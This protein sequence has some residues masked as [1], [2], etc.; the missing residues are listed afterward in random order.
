MKRI[1][2]IVIAVII[3]LSIYAQTNDSKLDSLIRKNYDYYQNNDISL[4]IELGT[5]IIGSYSDR[6]DITDRCGILNTLSLCYCNKEDF[7]HAIDC[8]LQLLYLLLNSGNINKL[9]DRL[10][11]DIAARYIL[12]PHVPNLYKL[13]LAKIIYKVLAFDTIS[14]N[15]WDSFQSISD[16]AKIDNDYDMLTEFIDHSVQLILLYNRHNI[17]LSTCLSQIPLGKILNPKDMKSYVDNL[18]SVELLIF[19]STTNTSTLIRNTDIAITAAGYELHGCIEDALY[20]IDDIIY[21]NIKE[22]YDNEQYDEVI[23]YKNAII[24]HL[25]LIP[26]EKTARLWEYVITAIYRTGNLGYLDTIEQYIENN[27]LLDMMSYQQ[28]YID[29]TLTNIF[30]QINDTLRIIEIEQ[31]DWALT[32]DLDFTDVSYRDLYNNFSLLYYHLLK[33]ML[34][35]PNTTYDFNE[36]MIKLGYD[37]LTDLINEVALRSRQTFEFGYY[38]TALDMA[39]TAYNMYAREGLLCDDTIKSTYCICAM[40]YAA[41][42]LEYYGLYE[43]ATDLLNTAMTSLSLQKL[44]EITE[45]EQLLALSAFSKIVDIWLK[46]PDNDIER[47][48]GLIEIKDKFESIRSNELNNYYFYSALCRYYYASKNYSAAEYYSDL[49]YQ[50]SISINDQFQW[51][52]SACAEMISIRGLCKIHLDRYDDGVEDIK[53]GLQYP[54]SQSLRLECQK[55]LM[56]YNIQKDSEIAILDILNA[57]QNIEQYLKIVIAEREK[58]YLITSADRER[59]WN[60]KHRE[61]TDIIN[62]YLTFFDRFDY[63]SLDKWF[64]NVN[65]YVADVI[66]T[67]LLYSKGLLL[68]TDVVIDSILRNNDN[69]DVRKIYSRYKKLN[70]EILKMSPQGAGYAEKLAMLQTEEN[71]LMTAIRNHNIEIEETANKITPDDII[72]GLSDHE[73]AIEFLYMPPSDYRAD[74]C[75]YAI[76]LRN[77]NGSNDKLIKVCTDSQLKTYLQGGIV[78]SYK[79]IELSNLIW[80]NILKLACIDDKDTIYFSP[81]GFLH[82]YAIEYLPTEDGRTMF[83]KYNII[84]LTSTSEILSKKS[85]NNTPT[86]VLYGGLKYDLNNTT[87]I[88]YSNIV[89]SYRDNDL[90]YNIISENTRDSDFRADEI[91]ELPGTLDEV[92]SIAELLHDN[93]IANQSFI[94]AQGTEAS[95]KALSGHAPKWLLIATH[96]FFMSPT[97][98]EMDS[99]RSIENKTAFDDRRFDSSIDYSMSRAG[100]L[101]AGASAALH[102][103]YISEKDDDGILT[104]LEISQLNL[105]NID[106]VV[107]SACQTAMGDITNDGVAGLQRGF[108]KS[109]VQTIVMSLWKV[110]DNATAILMKRFYEN[111]TLK[112][113]ATKRDAFNDAIIYLRNY[114]DK[115]TVE[116]DDLSAEPVYDPVVKS[117][118]YPKKTVYENHKIYSDPYYWAAFIMLD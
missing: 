25:P 39:N 60:I 99:R 53:R 108:K 70:I 48:S 27:D 29:N 9:C 54:R 101:F 62:R 46:M 56:L 11:K 33:V 52:R 114:E 65:S 49:A 17:E 19:G 2:V 18:L 13:D 42:V 34:L 38:S 14:N 106:L 105:S 24:D 87:D 31:P 20:H 73:I 68:R 92:N 93:G 51:V 41:D 112:R 83:E 81:D 28:K 75:Y 15:R 77:N 50:S 118:V 61:V 23:N 3:P 21:N 90:V 78:Q 66:Y 95:F 35:F 45:D 69:D 104:A 97:R 107:L 110:S 47:L 113:F 102:G 8:D 94:G 44:N 111:M 10:L 22:L 72:S 103:E 86:S 98:A 67:W 5:K 55:V 79:S 71:N 116:Y 26:P 43:H 82:Q 58:L 4:S 1:Y 59:A 36:I 117:Y 7:D 85:D 64:Q 74:G 6:L 76:V 30:S 109:G 80:S 37:C 115:I 84:R 32:G 89:G 96:G 63:D 91:K 40:S 100:L 12:Y 57:A 16:R 88:N